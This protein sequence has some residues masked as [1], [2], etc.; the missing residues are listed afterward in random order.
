M[1][2]GTIKD[3]INTTGH[4]GNIRVNSYGVF[5]MYGGTVSGGEATINYGG[6]IYASGATLNLLGGSVVN[7]VGRMGGNIATQKNS[8]AGVSSVVNLKNVTISGGYIRKNTAVEGSVAHG[9]NIS[10]E[11][12]TM[13]IEDGTYIYGGDAEGQG[14]NLRALYCNITMNGGYITGGKV[15][16]TSVNENVWLV[17]SA[18][19]KGS[20]TMN[21]GVIYANSATIGAGSGI[22]A[23]ANTT[24]TLAGDAIVIANPANPNKPISTSG[25]LV[26]D[27]SW[28]G[29]AA[30]NKD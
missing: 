13:T 11:R 12:T 3:G 6:N 1:Y 21:G 5:T 17:G 26:K 14:G 15:G 29:I 25:D 4:G 30:S 9:G 2:G 22:H 7:G 20:F 28:A 19:E 18:S 27:P 8:T 23:T 16:G 24:I 10:V